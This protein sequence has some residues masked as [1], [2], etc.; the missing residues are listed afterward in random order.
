MFPGTKCFNDFTCVCDDLS[1]S[2]KRERDFAEAVAQ[3]QAKMHND[4]QRLILMFQ[5]I[6]LK[7][8]KY[9]GTTKD[10][11]VTYSEQICLF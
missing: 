6:L 9:K 11:N 5:D 10:M 3:M 2:K 4:K 7:R 1:C 8:L